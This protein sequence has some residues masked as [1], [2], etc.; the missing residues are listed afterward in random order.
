MSD[1]PTDAVP[2]QE[3]LFDP[4]TPGFSAD[5]HPLFRRMREHARFIGHPADSGLSHATTTL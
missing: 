2:P 1:R 3:A 5:P 4:L